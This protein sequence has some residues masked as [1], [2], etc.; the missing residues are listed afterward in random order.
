MVQIF[1][2]EETCI[3]FENVEAKNIGLLY[4]KLTSDGTILDVYVDDVFVK[5]V[6]ARFSNGWGN[7]MG[8]EEIAVFSESGIH[9]VKIVPQNIDGASLIYVS[10]L[11]VS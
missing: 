8:A 9:T 5:S 11:L 2:G 1:D 7:Y 3:L 10:E 4:G 6:D